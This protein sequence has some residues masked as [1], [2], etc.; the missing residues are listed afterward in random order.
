MTVKIS[1]TTADGRKLVQ[2]FAGCV[3]PEDG[4]Q[5]AKT[6][7]PG[8]KITKAEELVEKKK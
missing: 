7:F 2:N 1:L 3:D 6:I 5:K 4:K 8:C